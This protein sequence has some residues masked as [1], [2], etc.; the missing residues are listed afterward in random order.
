MTTLEER[1]RHGQQ[2]RD[3]L[4]GGDLTHYT[5]PGTDALAPDL[6]RIIDESLFGS[7]WN[8]GGLD[9]KLRCIATLAGLM[10]LGEL[11]LLRRTIERCLNVGL[12][13][14]QVVEVFIQMTFY[15]GVPAVEDAMNL[16]KDI[17]EAK[18]IKYTPTRAYNTER[19]TDELYEEGVRIHQEY[20]PEITV[21]RTDDPDSQEN[22]LDRIINEYHWGAICSRPHLD[23]KARVI[24]GL[25]CMT[26][27]GQYDRQMRARIQGALRVGLTPEEIME[28]FIQL[29][30]Y[31]GYFNT[32]TAM[33]IARSVFTEEGQ[34]A[35]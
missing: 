12:S 31:G 14:G 18:G 24:C 15:V 16:T 3:T 21:Y 28:V 27:M 29:T 10:A 6:K 20:I 1:Y 13:P 25:A 32:R 17:F 30:M 33:R 7:I 34:A 8:R 22:Q 19:T 5:L 4:A 26:V 11:P 2:M 9:L 23:P 35:G